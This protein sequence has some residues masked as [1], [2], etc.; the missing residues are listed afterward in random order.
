M[1]NKLPKI[2]II[3]PAYKAQNTILRTLSS[4]AIQEIVDDVE[5]TIVNDAD[6]IG[7]QKFVDMFSPFM[8]V[9]ELVMPKNGGPGDARQYG[10]DNTTNPLLMFIDADDTF[11]GAFALKTLRLQL[12]AEPYNACYYK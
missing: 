5:V 7:Y 10:I 6:G 9:R 2:D 4:I 1:E 12:L 8:K 11:S 3:I